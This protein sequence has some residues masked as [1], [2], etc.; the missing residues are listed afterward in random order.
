MGELNRTDGRAG[1]GIPSVL[2]IYASLLVAEAAFAVILAMLVGSFVL[3]VSLVDLGVPITAGAGSIGALFVER[4]VLYQLTAWRPQLHHLLVSALPAAPVSLAL[5]SRLSW[6]PWLAIPTAVAVGL[7]V[8]ALTLSYLAHSLRRR[9]VGRD[10]A[11]D[12]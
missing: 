9:T 10:Q 12:A 4:A 5:S 7:V 6:S 1:D 3:F 2:A 8:Q 11:L